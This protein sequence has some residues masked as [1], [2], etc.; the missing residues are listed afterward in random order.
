MPL[1]AEDHWKRS[2]LGFP[3]GKAPA[4][5]EETGARE[6][7]ERRT[8]RGDLESCPCL[9]RTQSDRL[10]EVEVPPGPSLAIRSGFPLG[11][12]NFELPRIVSWICRGL[13]TLIAR[14]WRYP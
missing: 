5:E 1:A 7:E 4:G 14:L 10:G 2:D 6:R 11:Q 9:R 8:G 13:L 3:E 12:P